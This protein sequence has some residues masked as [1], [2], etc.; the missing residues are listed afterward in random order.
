MPRA[1]LR[2]RLAFGSPP[3]SHRDASVV[4]HNSAAAIVG[5]LVYE[6]FQE[7]VV[8]LVHVQWLHHYMLSAQFDAWHGLFQ[9]PLFWTPV[10]RCAWVRALWAAVPLAVTFVV[11]RRRD[12]SGE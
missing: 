10:I 2:Q 11:F 5:T 3:G 4:T 1:G 9:T 6:L 7:A 8:G 12:V